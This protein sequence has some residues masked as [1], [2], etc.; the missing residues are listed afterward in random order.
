MSC[1]ECPTVEEHGSNG[2]L[3]VGEPAVLLNLGAFRMKDNRGSSLVNG[4]LF[5]H[6]RNTALSQQS[7][8]QAEEQTASPGIVLTA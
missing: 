1:F 5:E 8:Q 4:S 6:I 7:K 2:S 3:S